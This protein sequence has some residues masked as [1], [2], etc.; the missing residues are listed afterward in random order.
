MKKYIEN[1]NN[2][3]PCVGAADINSADDK[4]VLAGFSQSRERSGFLREFQNS[5][6]K[7]NLLMIFHEFYLIFLC[8]YKLYLIGPLV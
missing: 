8:F 1:K 2:D 3:L 6:F 5:L 7:F 4:L